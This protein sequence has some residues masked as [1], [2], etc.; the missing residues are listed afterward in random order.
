M[1]HP[2]PIL[3]YLEEIARL[4]ADPCIL[5]SSL[6]PKPK[7]PSILFDIQFDGVL[8]SFSD[9]YFKDGSLLRIGI[10]GG[11]FDPVHTGHLLVAETVREQMGLDKVLFIPAFQ[12]PL[13]LD[14]PPTAGRARSEM[15]QLAI[16]GHPSFELD[17]RELT[18][19]GVSYTIDTIRELRS[20]QP[21]TE[22]YFLMGADSLA[23]L[24]RW[25]EPEQLCS[26]AIPVV[27]TR[28]G[29]APPDLKAIE[30]FLDSARMAI[31]R[32]HV[33]NMPQ[34]EISSRD[35]RLRVQNKKSIRYQVP[36][37]VEAYIKTHNLYR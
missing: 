32:Q 3:A 9:F 36:A 14:Y 5:A 21:D 26:L 31:V 33:V 2:I 4:V 23:D 30:P 28:G 37:S 16:G 29:C 6:V 15:L 8:D 13:K 35:L 25:K 17:E 27:V 34:M 20:E 24:G 10:Y 22:W 1:L 19:G 11:S 18:R 12:S 7:T